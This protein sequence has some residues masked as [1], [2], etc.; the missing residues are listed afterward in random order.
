[1]GGQAVDI[2]EH[3]GDPV[4]LR[5]LVERA[6]EPPHQLGAQQFLVGEGRSIRRLEP[7]PRAVARIATDEPKV[8]VVP[9]FGRARR[10][11][12]SQPG[13]YGIERNPIHPRRQRGVSS[14]GAYLPVDLE[15][16]VLRDFLRVLAAPGVPERE[17]EDPLAVGGGKLINRRLIAFAHAGDEHPLDRSI[18]T[19]FSVHACRTPGPRGL[20]PLCLA[21]RRLNS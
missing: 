3:Y 17:L 6:R 14:E 18:R 20:F 4:D 9:P 21:G 5:E 13:H 1:V 2:A 8:L 10:P 7:R 16:H 15:Q 11:S 19:M 12:A